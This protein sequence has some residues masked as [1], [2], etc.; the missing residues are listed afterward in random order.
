MAGVPPSPTLIREVAG[1]TPVTDSL[2]TTCHDTDEP[3]VGLLPERLIELPL[4]ASGRL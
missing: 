2:N 1:L 4:V 3:L